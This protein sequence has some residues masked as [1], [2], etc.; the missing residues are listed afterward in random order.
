MFGYHF[1]LNCFIKFQEIS[2]IGL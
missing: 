1:F 2:L